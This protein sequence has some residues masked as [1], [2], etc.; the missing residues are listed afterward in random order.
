M[1]I[2][3]INTTQTSLA[4]PRSKVS[5]LYNLVCVMRFSHVTVQDGGRILARGCQTLGKNLSKFIISTFAS[6]F[7]F[8]KLTLPWLREGK[9]WLGSFGWFRCVCRR[10]SAGKGLRHRE[11]STGPYYRSRFSLSHFAIFEL[12]F[13]LPTIPY[14]KRN[15]QSSL[16][17]IRACSF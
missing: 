7:L 11:I 3:P 15:S 14:V 6:K 8:S 16:S 17:C 9:W 5:T 1:C 4:S 10:F 12:Y 13:R 2:K